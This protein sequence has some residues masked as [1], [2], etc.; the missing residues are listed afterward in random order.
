MGE[1][2]AGAANRAQ[3]GVR[4]YCQYNALVLTVR[5]Y[6]PAD[7]QRL[8]AIDQSCF[9]E[10]IAYTEEEMRYFLAMPSAIP[11]VALSG[12]KILGFIIA[13]RFRPRR[14]TRS[15]GKIITIDVAPEVRHSGTG[16]LLMSEAE[17]A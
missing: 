5:R 10:G 11:L 6:Q 4:F 14:A 2:D 7:F 16:T 17:A 12:D 3:S 13:D 1:G 9:T 8:L 15:M